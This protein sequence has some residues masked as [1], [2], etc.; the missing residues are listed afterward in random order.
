MAKTHQNRAFRKGFPVSKH[1]TNLECAVCDQCFLFTK[2]T[3][4]E[5]F[6][7]HIDHSMKNFQFFRKNRI[8]VSK[9]QRVF[10]KPYF[11]ILN[12]FSFSIHVLAIV[13]LPRAL[14][15][16]LSTILGCD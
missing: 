8:T 2:D 5:F 12:V 11:F 13:L 16:S 10:S 7:Q 3:S 14:E 6:S 4:T 1:R 15:A 9:N